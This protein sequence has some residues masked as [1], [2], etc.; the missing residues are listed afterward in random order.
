MWIRCLGR[1]RSYVDPNNDSIPIST[2]NTIVEATS[3]PIAQFSLLALFFLDFLSWS[4]LS[5]HV[6]MM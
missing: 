3:N 6:L 4:M 1:M 5:I 2:A